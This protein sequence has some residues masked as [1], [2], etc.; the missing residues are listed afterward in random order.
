MR[1]RRESER[2]RAEE[3]NAQGGGQKAKRE[4]RATTTTIRQNVR[5]SV[6]ATPTALPSVYFFVVFSV[7][8]I[9]CFPFFF[10]ALHP[11]PQ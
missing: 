6:A 4:Q 10:C 5:G 11:L 8:R 2:E 7:R 1:G 3:E 9:S